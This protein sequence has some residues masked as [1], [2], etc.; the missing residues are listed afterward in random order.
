MNQ[1]T[2]LELREAEKSANRSLAAG[3]RPVQGEHRAPPSNLDPALAQSHRA[4][5]HKAG[6]VYRHVVLESGLRMPAAAY[7]LG[8][9]AYL[10][11]GC[12]TLGPSDLDRVVDNAFTGTS[13]RSLRVVP[14]P[15]RRGETV[16][17][18]WDIATGGRSIRWTLSI[19]GAVEGT[20]TRTSD[21]GCSHSESVT[22]LLSRY[23][24]GAHTATLRVFEA[25]S[26]RT[27]ND[28]SASFTL[29][30]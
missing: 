7:V 28:L 17:F 19:N 20:G 3:R 12:N 16:Q 13:A 25:A 6:R 8:A 5:V 30:N 11:V 29:S 10:S 23:G 9:L 26:D 22:T 15:A 1:T 27:I 24:A 18:L 4:S 21:C 2:P 14:N